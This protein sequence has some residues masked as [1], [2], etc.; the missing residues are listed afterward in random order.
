MLPFSVSFR[1]GEPAYAQVVYAAVRA[2]VSGQLRPGD[3]FPSVRALSQEL[4]INPNTA[5]KVIGALKE[6]GLLE[7]RSGVGTLVASAPGLGKRERALLLKEQ[8]EQLVVEAMRLRM[9]CDEVVE[10]VRE[11]WNRFSGGKG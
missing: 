2:M 8:T 11:H 1:A 5:Q 3:P 10:S 7:V 9:G 4:R 6:K